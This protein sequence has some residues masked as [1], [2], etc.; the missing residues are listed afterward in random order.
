M[1]SSCSEAR[2]AL[3]E[4]LADSPLF[5]E[6][7]AVKECVL[8]SKDHGGCKELNTALF[9]CRRGQVRKARNH[10]FFYSPLAEIILRVS[11]ARSSTCGSASKAI[12]TFRARAIKR[13]AMRAAK[14]R[15]ADSSC[16]ARVESV[17][18]ELFEELLTAI[19][20]RSETHTNH[21][22]PNVL[23]Q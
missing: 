23:K 17:Q 1:A 9:N 4:C 15:R 2:A 14:R 16:R 10:S 13:R 20:S 3:V 12:S 11:C 6:G 19:V 18:C 21:A 7:K 5:L 22:Q 8:L